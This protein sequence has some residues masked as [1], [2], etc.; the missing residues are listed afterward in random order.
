[1]L[2][3]SLSV[4]FKNNLCCD[5]FVF[6]LNSRELVITMVGKKI[7]IKWHMTTCSR[8]ETYWHF[9]ESPYISSFLRT[10]LPNFFLRTTR[11]ICL[12]WAIEFKSC[13]SYG[14]L[15][16]FSI[17]VVPSNVDLV[18]VLTWQWEFHCAVSLW[19][20]TVTET[21]S[22]TSLSPRTLNVI[23]SIPA[24][25]TAVCLWLTQYSV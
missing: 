12:A 4:T 23:A 24:P 8:I 10:P 2:C 25:P 16:V 3:Y 19:Q 9:G 1:M 18:V 22:R 21:L 15:L 7:I 14:S 5:I 13:F 17:T 6:P 20:V 11:Q